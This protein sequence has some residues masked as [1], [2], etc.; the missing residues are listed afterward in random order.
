[1]NPVYQNTTPFSVKGIEIVD[2][3]PSTTLQ[4]SLPV[5]GSSAWQM[6]EPLEISISRP[7]TF[8]I[9]GVIYAFLP[10]TGNGSYGSSGLSLFHTRAPFDLL[11]ATIYLISVPSKC[12]ISKFLYITGDEAG[13]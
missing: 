7:L 8:I 2:S 11:R 10:I 3:A 9:I 13:P 6:A 12:R 1:M 5:L 4:I